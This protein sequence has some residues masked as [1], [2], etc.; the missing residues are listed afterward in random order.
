[1]AGGRAVCGCSRSTARGRH[2]VAACPAIIRR[3]AEKCCTARTW[4]YARHAVCLSCCKR[5]CVFE[6]FMLFVCLHEVKFCS[7]TPGSAGSVVDVGRERTNC[8]GSCSAS[9]RNESIAPDL[10]LRRFHLLLDAA[11]REGGGAFSLSTSPADA[12]TLIASP[13]VACLTAARHWAMVSTRRT[14]APSGPPSS[15]RSSSMRASLPVSRGMMRFSC[16]ASIRSP[17]WG[18]D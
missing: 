1:M 14:S 5:R 12:R 9:Y 15:G 13:V 7:I 18:V 3:T 4:G 6:S 17:P 11:G 8:G 16:C 2:G 10:P